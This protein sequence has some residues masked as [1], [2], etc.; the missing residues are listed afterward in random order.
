[1]RASLRV[2]RLLEPTGLAYIADA[3]ASLDLSRY[4][5]FDYLTG[6]GA[7]KYYA[8]N[9][10]SA[11]L[12]LQAHAALEGDAGTTISTATTTAAARV[13]GG[14]GG[15]LADQMDALSTAWRARTSS[16]GS[17]GHPSLADYGGDPDNFLECV[18]SY[19]HA[20][21]AL[22]AANTWMMRQVS[23]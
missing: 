3:F 4:N 22:Q 1:M 20:A 21:P 8:F 23:V 2:R 15:R 18:P 10:F 12:A 16:N 11:F 14:G 5:V 9:V 7:G 6:A 13:G 17:L 19:I